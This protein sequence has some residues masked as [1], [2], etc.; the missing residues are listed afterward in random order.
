MPIAAIR[1]VINRSVAERVAY[2][3]SP[4]DTV[5]RLRPGNFRCL[6]LCLR[7]TA[8]FLPEPRLPGAPRPPRSDAHN[9]IR[10]IRSSAPAL[11]ADTVQHAGPSA[12]GPSP[13][14]SVN[15]CKKGKAFRTRS[16]TRRHIFHRYSLPSSRLV[17]RAVP[18]PKFSKSWKGTLPFNFG[19]NASLFSKLPGP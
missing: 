17:N 5:R 8:F 10:E 1:L 16:N 4:R 9:Q 2:R 19:S 15:S 12:C 13:N 14:G 18:Y 3:D 7:D 11:P 6:R